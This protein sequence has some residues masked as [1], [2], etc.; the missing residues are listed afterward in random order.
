MK[1]SF[2]EHALSDAER[3]W[4]REATRNEKFDPKTAKAV[5]FG[6]LPDD[7]DPHG[8]DP[9]VYSGSRPTLIGLWLIEPDHPIFDAI[10][11]VISAIRKEILAKPGIESATA[12]DLVSLTGLDE[13]LV[14]RA[15]WEIREA[16]QGG[17]GQFFSDVTYDVAN[18]RRLTAIQLRYDNAYD[19]YLRYKGLEELLERMY[20]SRTPGIRPG[21]IAH[22]L[23]ERQKAK[24]LR[25]GVPDELSQESSKPNTAFVLM[26]MDPD[27]PALEDVYTAIKDAFLAFDITARRV[28]EIE[29][30][31]PITDRILSEIRTCAY[32]VADLT[33]ERPNVYYEIGYAHAI[34]KNPI[35]YRRAGTSLHF[36]LSV[37]NVP[38]Y[39]NATELRNHLRERLA[40][41]LGREP[42]A[43]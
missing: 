33:H 6:K 10:D 30:Q 7:F 23:S 24:G 40:T 34:H 25:R 4:L 22:L 36:D 37:H 2:Q 16:D 21:G 26:A 19:E 13:V 27:E 35:L 32:L 3:L 42:K 9:R 17:I 5:L 29:H 1:S 38:E 43:P 15:L 8:I 12:V 11:R 20:T 39:K 14:S 28:D 18:T 31:G 41:I